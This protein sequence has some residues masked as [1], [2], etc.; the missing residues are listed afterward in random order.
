MEQG[1]TGE[2]A[3]EWIAAWNSHDLERILAYYTDDF[4]MSSPLIVERMKEPGGTLRG[5]AAIR[6]Y[7]SKGLAQEP[8]L[9]FELLGVYAGVDRIAV[10]YRS[11]GRGLVVEVLTFNAAGKVTHGAALHGEPA[12]PA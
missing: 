8:P 10:L 3:R 11:V 2:F 12:S 7:W 4:E 1:R 6:H 5:K 9:R